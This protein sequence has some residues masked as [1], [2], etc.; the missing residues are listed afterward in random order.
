MDWK[1]RKWRKEKNY[2]VEITNGKGEKKGKERRGE[3]RGD[4]KA[5]SPD[6]DCLYKKFK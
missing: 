2:V 3:E 4:M 6:Q 1:S 5:L